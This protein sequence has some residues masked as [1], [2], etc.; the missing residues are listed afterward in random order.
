M[1]PQ[2]SQPVHTTRP[3]AESSKPT[4]WFP[5][6]S[7]VVGVDGSTSSIHAVEWAARQAALE[8]RPL[9]LLHTFH[10]DGIY[11]LPAMGYDPRE[12]RH[13][14]STE[15]DRLLDAAEERVAELAPDV[16]VHRV[17]GDA[18]ARTALIEA[19][20]HALMVVLG[21]RG[22]GPVASTFLGSVGVTVIRHA[23]C[24][25]VVRRPEHDHVSHGVLVG[26]DMTE[27]SRP[28]LEFAYRL[29]AVRG[30]PL[31][32][33]VDHHRSPF[34]SDQEVEELDRMPRERVGLWLGEL[35]AKFPEVRVTERETVEPFSRALGTLGAEQDV[36]VVGGPSGGTLASALGRSAA[37]AVV[38]H[39][40][41][42]V[43][44]VPVG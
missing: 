21:S 43:V 19:S 14:L 38:E 3:E 13:A 6:G 24:P 28:V 17:L 2:G 33:M 30:M 1:S 9:A 31:T 4:L 35:H 27:A 41:A 42:T 29:A 5:A 11:W 18:D 23:A 25:V 44:V 40:P 12:I 10:I 34:L 26:T 8:H 15:G 20:R 7:V 22:R 36:V 39:V 37:V 32:V 16:E